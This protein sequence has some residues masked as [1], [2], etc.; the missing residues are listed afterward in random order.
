MKHVLV[1]EDDPEACRLI[2]DA[3]M[4]GF[5]GAERVQSD[6]AAYLRIPSLPTLDDL[7]VHLA[8]RGGAGG[9]ALRPSGDPTIP[10]AYVGARGTM[11]PL[12][13]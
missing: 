6:F 10:I 3:L 5:I 11:Q 7:I 9:P 13:A 1:Y 4:K 12:A 2:R 8:R